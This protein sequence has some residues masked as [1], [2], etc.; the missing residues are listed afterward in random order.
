[1]MERNP[2]LGQMLNNPAMMQQIMEV[3]RNPVSV[4]AHAC[5][6]WKCEGRMCDRGFGQ[7]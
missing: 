6:G 5:V 1:M 7:G 3:A 4:D 2:E